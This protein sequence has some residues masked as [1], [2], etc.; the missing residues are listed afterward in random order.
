MRRL[1]AAIAALPLLL[2]GIAPAVHAQTSG[3]LRKYPAGWNLVAIPAGTDFFVASTIYTAQ[4]Y[5]L[6]YEQSP[7]SQ[8]TITGYGYW[9]DITSVDASG[10][11]RGVG[12]TSGSS[13]P[14]TINVPAGQWI[15]VGNPS[16]MLLASIQGADTSWTYDPVNGYQPTTILQPGQGAWVASA[17]GALVTVTPIQPSGVAQPAWASAPVA[18]VAPA[19][20][21]QVTAVVAAPN[22]VIPNPNT[23]FEPVPSWTWWPF[24][25]LTSWA[26]G[27]YWTAG[28]SWAGSSPSY[29]WPVCPGDVVTAF[30]L[31]SCGSLIGAPAPFVP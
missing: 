12:L 10:Y 24:P 17:G 7:P 27:P 1:L 9:A 5:D 26:A 15:M 3:Q 30:A 2:A 23:S 31:D 8:G 22:P 16:G 25:P 14:Y 20:P 4:P 19:P 11:S 29:N 28:F 21:S 6:G 13:A 18:S